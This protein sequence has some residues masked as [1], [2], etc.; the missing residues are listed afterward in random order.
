MEH[1][2]LRLAPIE[3]P[4]GLLVRLAYWLSKRQYGKVLTPMKVVYARKPGLINIVRH[5]LKV[6]KSLT[7]EPA[8]QYLVSVQ[9]SRMNGCPFCEDIGLAHAVQNRIGK[10]RFTALEDFRTSPSFT[11]RER[12]ALAFAEEATRN[13]SVSEETWATVKKHFNDTQ[14]VELVWLN[15]TENY[16]N[17]TAA[18]LGIGSDELAGKL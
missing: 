3:K 18:V 10:E 6:Q 12:A 11:E 15:A 17:L 16:F 5:I 1:D 9:V 7:L 14:I 2:K 4:R 13:H 8:I